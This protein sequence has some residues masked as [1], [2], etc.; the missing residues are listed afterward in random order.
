M[1]QYPSVDGLY[2]FNLINSNVCATIDILS[3]I[4]DDRFIYLKKICRGLMATICNNKCNELMVK[5]GNLL[6]AVS[7]QRRYGRLNPERIAVLQG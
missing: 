1:A 2:S 6:D 4:E 7:G 5:S 3:S